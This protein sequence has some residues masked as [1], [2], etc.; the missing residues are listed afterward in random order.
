MEAKGLLSSQSIPVLNEQYSSADL[1]AVAKKTREAMYYIKRDIKA[2]SRSH[3]YL[4]KA[5]N[6]YILL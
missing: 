5:I 1:E 4:E 6:Y 2:R 3:C